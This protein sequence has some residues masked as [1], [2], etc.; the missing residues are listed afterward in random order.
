MDYSN[1]SFY[2]DIT[3]EVGGAR[4]TLILL[5]G[6]TK[7]YK[8]Y[9]YFIVEKAKYNVRVAIHFSFVNKVYVVSVNNFYFDVR[10]MENNYEIYK[11]NFENLLNSGLKFHK[12]ADLDIWYKLYSEKD[13]LPQL[14][15]VFSKYKN[16]LS[17][18]PIMLNIVCII[19]MNGL[20]IPE[21]EIKYIMDD[22]KDDEGELNKNR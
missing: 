18:R 20:D 13:K 17:N 16:I 3:I 22:V 6:E 12:M 14:N 1:L 10:N 7:K 5:M 21:E 11:Y 8:A 19:Y 2:D 9:L 4:D 15:N